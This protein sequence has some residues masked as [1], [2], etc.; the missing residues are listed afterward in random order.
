MNERIKSH[1]DAIFSDA[2]DTLKVRDLKEELLSNLSLKYEDLIAGGMSQEDAYRQV[3]A[4]I[5]DVSELL[6]QIQN[7]R[8]YNSRIP[9]GNSH[10]RAVLVAISVG[11]FIL[12][13]MCVV[14]FDALIPGS[15]IGVPLMFVLIAIGV[16]LQVYNQ[17][18]KP[19]YIKRDE[20]VVE[21]FKQWK[22]ETTRETT[23][24]RSMS[25]ILWLVIVIVYLLYSFFLGAWA[26]SWILFL[27]GA[28]LEA[29]IRLCFQI[30]GGK[31]K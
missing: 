31:K 29:I 15:T 25:S 26:Y 19:R 4:S 7:E 16:G 24:R 11:L 6:L 28:L 30:F 9:D 3:V 10:R 23:I 8:A 21:E 22:S 12:S 18:T 5:G 14:F 20:T 27:I 13:P 1:V 2:P 17:M